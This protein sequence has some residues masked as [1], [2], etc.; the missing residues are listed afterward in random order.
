MMTTIFFRDRLVKTANNLFL[1]IFFSFSAE[2][3][4]PEFTERALATAGIPPASVSV[5]VQKVGAASPLLAHNADIPRNPAS[6]I[7][8]VTTLAALDQLGPAYHWTTELLTDGTLHEGVLTG[9][10]YL[11]GNGDPKL[12]YDRFWL[13][14]RQ[15]RDRGIR[16]IRGDLVLDRSAFTPD[17]SNPAEFDGKPLR[18]YNAQPD[19]L[20]FNFNALTLTLRPAERG[21]GIE[22][23]AQPAPD[24][25]V[26]EN[27]LRRSTTTTCGDWRE[28]LSATPLVQQGKLRQPVITRLRLSGDYP[29]SC[30]EREWSIQAMRADELLAGSFRSLWRELGGKFTGSVRV[31][32]TPDTALPLT[33]SPSLSLAEIVRD[34][35]KFSNNVM[36]R[37]L[38][39]TLSR[40][41]PA[42]EAAA[43]QAI[44]RWLNEK[45]I[46]LPQLVLGNGSGLSRDGRLSATE[47]TSLLRYGW[48]SPVM[49]E[50]IASLPIVASD[51]TMQKR[52]RDTALA[53]RA[54][55][56]TGSL[57]GVKS[58]AGYVLD[59]QGQRWIVVFLVNHPQAAAAKDAMDG[60][61]LWVSE[62]ASATAAP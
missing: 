38:F 48:Q 23:S 43:D 13:M 14:L 29:E 55:I 21:P 8:L 25:L 4:L 31:A 58:L 9:N 5:V 15:L 49:P 18:P 20:L 12:S 62:G 61:L 42:T 39:L 19:A 51:G 10:L 37:Q 53:G 3:A 16:D 60:L 50:F 30:G 40:T 56:K 34:T 27:R 26:V 2:A 45:N 57:D 24:N 46:A 32:R 11:R 36:A 44:R 28:R 6:V 41:V 52:L 35:N 54:H 1:L 33:V 17:I 47:L 59:S 7:K 22:V